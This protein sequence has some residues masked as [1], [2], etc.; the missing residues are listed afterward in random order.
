MAAQG[1]RAAARQTAGMAYELTGT[2]VWS[3]PLRYGDPTETAEAAAEVESLG[4]SA[5]WLPDVGGELLDAVANLLAATQTATIAT[6]IL[7]LWM[8]D[9]AEVAARHAALT[10]EHGHR[11]LMGIGVSHSPLIDLAEAGKYR[12]PLARMREFLD[13]LDDAPRPVAPGDRVL[14][15][16]GPKML[17]LARTRSAGAH[18][19]LVTPQNTATTREALG[20]GML[21]APE[22]A[23]VLDTDP[24]S[25]RAAAR[26]HL[27]TYLG[28]PNYANNWLRT[29]FTE[30][31]I[32][33][34]GSDRLVD[35]L[36]VWG[37]EDTIAARIQE[38]RDAGADHVC[39]QVITADGRALG[40]DVL[41]R[42][43]SALT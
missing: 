22:Q 13:G 40:L 20:H 8:H 19:Y 21:V 38:H 31:D 24:E 27:A 18:P 29:G 26:G 3:A 12:R 43:A 1:I 39:I 25:A 28:L 9:P 4:Y 10:D 42:L 36:V 17:E 32:A 6:G 33:D 15:A 37:D 41:R 23:V 34:G 2:G 14:A 35:A 30:D 11:F 7:N 5:I 16:L